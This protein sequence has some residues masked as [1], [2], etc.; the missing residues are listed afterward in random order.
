M[1][2]VTWAVLRG[3]PGARLK[4]RFPVDCL[5]PLVLPTGG[6]GETA[7]NPWTTAHATDALLLAVWFMLREMEWAAVR[8]QD[9]EAVGGTVS[10]RPPAAKL[11]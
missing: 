2:R 4:A 6:A 10:L 7:W 8:T 5:A 3:S 11:R 9:L 1:R